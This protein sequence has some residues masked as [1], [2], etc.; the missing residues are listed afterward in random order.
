M[1]A[2]KETPFNHANCGGRVMEDPRFTWVDTEGMI[3]KGVAF[4]AW[5]CERCGRVPFDG[6]EPVRK[7]ERE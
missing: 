7:E 6:S 4:E 5:V 2:P 1:N 3:E